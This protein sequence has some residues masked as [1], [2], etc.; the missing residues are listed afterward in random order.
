MPD[1]LNRMIIEALKLPKNVILRSIDID[2]QGRYWITSDG[3]LLSVC[4]E[5]PLYKRFYDNGEGYYYTEINGK[6]Y[7]LHRLLA[8][9]FN[10]NQEKKKIKNCVVHHLDRNKDNNNLSNLCIVSKDKHQAIHSIWN[11][12]DSWRVIPWEELEI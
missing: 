9:S 1:Y 10:Q 4:R 6:K 11:K 12:L 8:L 2:E 3:K 7:Y 5:K